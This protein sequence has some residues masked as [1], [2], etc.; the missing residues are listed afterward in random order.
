[1]VMIIS[2]SGVLVSYAL[3]YRLV[4]NRLLPGDISTLANH[5]ESA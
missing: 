4:L 2:V 5:S 1:M 3:A